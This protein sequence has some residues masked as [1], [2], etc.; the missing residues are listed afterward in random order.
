MTYPRVN[1]RRSLGLGFERTPERR[2]QQR[3]A[4]QCGHASWD[5]RLH[6]ASELKE[7]TGG[8]FRVCRASIRLLQGI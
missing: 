3:R 2:G 8:E 5:L 1:P 6:V 7:T 4:S